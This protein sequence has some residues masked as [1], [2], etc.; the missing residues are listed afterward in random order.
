LRPQAFD[1]IDNGG[2]CFVI[3]RDALDR[4]GGGQFVDRRQRQNRFAL[5]ERLA[6]E[7]AFTAAEVG[8][9]FRRENRLDAWHRESRRRIDVS[10]ARVR[11]RA[12]Q[13]LAEQHAL[14]AIVLG[15]F[16]RR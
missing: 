14:G 8:E 2:E 12:Q 7:R 9:I 1:G 5:I 4:F 13:E 6:G 3:D 15:D 11:H 16:A 10:H